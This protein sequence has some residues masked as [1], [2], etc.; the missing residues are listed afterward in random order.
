MFLARMK[1]TCV[2]TLT[3]WISMLRSGHLPCPVLGARRV[4]DTANIQVVVSGQIGYISAWGRRG[5]RGRPLHIRTLAPACWILWVPGATRSMPHPCRHIQR[6][7]PDC[8]QCPHAP[9]VVESNTLERPPMYET[10]RQPGP[11]RQSNWTTTQYLT[12][13]DPQA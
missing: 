3:A 7:S 6:E 13:H 9:T 10:P 8:I 12:T 11:R 1:E 4:G 2:N 5:R